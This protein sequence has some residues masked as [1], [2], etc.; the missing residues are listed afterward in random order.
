M[1]TSAEDSLRR[2]LCSLEPPD[3]WQALISTFLSRDFADVAPVVLICGP[4]GSGKST[5]GRMLANAMLTKPKIQPQSN[6]EAQS[7]DPSV[8]VLDTDPGQ[9]EYSLPGELSI[10]QLYSCNLGPPFTHP[11]VV[12]HSELGS[13]IVKRQCFGSISPKDDPSHYL[14][15][16]AN[17]IK[18]S[19]PLLWGGEWR[20][21]VI[22]CS[23]WVQGGGLEVLLELIQKVS[24]TDVV[25]MSDAGPEGAMEALHQACFDRDTQFHTLTSPP[26][27][28]TTR[29]AAELRMMQTMSYY[30]IDEPEDGKLRWNPNPL[31]VI[32]PL[33]VHYSGSKQ[34]IFAVMILGDEQSPQN[35]ESILD[36]CIVDVV[37]IENESAIPSRRYPGESHEDK[38]IDD[39]PPGEEETPHALFHP[40]IRRSPTAIPYLPGKDH[41]VRPLA[42]KW[43]E[44]RGQAII[45]SVDIQNH[46]FH[47]VTP[48]AM[49][50]FREAWEQNFKIVLVRGKLDTPTWAY[51]EPLELE[52]SK[53]RSR[54]RKM[55]LKEDVDENEVQK[56]AERTPWASAVEGKR[57]AGARKRSGRRDLR[58][59]SQ[60]EG[61]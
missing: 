19:R 23:G 6:S 40:S 24:I 2:P 50:H 29:T 34:R 33:V 49:S 25:Y 20:P 39:Y 45:R 16:V 47:L 51:K 4:K 52:K 18:Y 32:P 42:P 48:R 10:A 21:V 46:A 43:T 27:H 31:T 15:C 11:G 9:P 35:F 14:D 37:L 13:G 7:D 36:G 26:V 17:L 38:D 12:S 1:R 8:W 44:S 41:V 59:R 54:E 56:W 58:Y 3:D 53:R 55:G 28:P 22:N 57:T 30:H 60:A 5:F 61:A